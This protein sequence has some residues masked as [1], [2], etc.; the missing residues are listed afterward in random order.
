MRSFGQLALIAAFFLNLLPAL[1][2]DVIT[3]FMSP[4]ASYQYPD[5]FTSESLTNGGIQSLAVSYQYPDNLTSEA[6]AGGEFNPAPPAIF[7]PTILAARLWSTAAS[8]RMSSATY[9]AIGRAT[10]S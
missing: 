3:N 7:I 9:I 5:D 6:L 2:D 8:N 1:A 10:M 4:V